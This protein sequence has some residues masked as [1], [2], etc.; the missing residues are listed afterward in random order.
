MKTHCNF[1]VRTVL[2]A[3]SAVALTAC[4][5]V[6]DNTLGNSRADDKLDIIEQVYRYGYRYD[7][8]DLEGLAA[9]FT[10]EATSVLIRGDNRQMG[11]IHDD[12]FMRFTQARMNE[13]VE[14][15]FVR[16]HYFTNLVVR[17]L[18]GDR[19]EVSAMVLIMNIQDNQVT[20]FLTAPYD[21]VFERHPDGWLISHLAIG[22]DV[23]F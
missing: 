20:P 2:L 6:S 11:R 14:S 12:N 3:L 4:V 5:N 16:R 18:D 10:P 13:K 9:L 7:D 15:G 23:V 17:K 1:I 22:S 21:F 19:A 8:N